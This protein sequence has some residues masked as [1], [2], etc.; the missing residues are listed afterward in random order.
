[1]KHKLLCIIVA[2]VTLMFFSK[3]NSGQAPDL[4]TAANFALFTSVGAVTNSGIPY[5]T[6]I[7]GNV[8]TNSDPT[9]TGFGNINGQ[10]H[11]VGD[12]GSTQCDADLLLASN[13]LAASIPDSTLGV[14]IGNGDTLPPGIYLMPG[15]ASLNLGLTLDAEGDPNA[16]FIFKTALAFSSGA[17]SKIYL[18]NGAQ[19]CNVFWKLDGAVTLGTGTTMR[20]TIISGGLISL[21][22]G[23]TLEGRALT[24]NGAILTDN[25]LVYTP[26]GCS[27]PAL[28]GPAAPSLVSMEC[29]TIF[30]SDGPVTNVGDTYVTGDVGT[31]NGL[32]TGY[33]PLFVTGMIHPIPDGATAAGA[34]DL[35]NAYAYLNALP[36]DIELLHPEM[37]GHNLVLTPHTYLMNG[38]VT[39]TDSLYLDAMGDADAIFII[40]T[41]GAFSTSTFSRVLLINGAIAKNI[42]WL[43][44]GAV[45]INDYSIFNGTIVCNNGAM[46]LNTGVIMNGR[47]LTTT[48]A[49]NTTAITAIMPPGCGVPPTNIITEPENIIVC[50]GDPA[51]FTVSVD[52]IGITYQWRIGTLNLTDGGNISGATTATLTIDP[53]TIADTSSF[54]NVVISG[55]PN[56]TSI[57]VSLMIDTG[58]VIITEPVNQTVCLGDSTGFTV[59]A[60]GSGLTYQWRNGTI[61]LIDGVNI[62]GA[63]SDTLVIN[64]V[65]LADTSSFYNVVITGAC[66]PSDTSINVSL[67]VDSVLAIITE[68]IDQ[69]VCDGNSVSFSVIASGTGLTYQWRNGNTDLI[70]GGNI[71]GANSATL[72]IDPA[73]IADTSSFYNVIISGSCGAN[74]TS[75][76]VSLGIDTSPEIIAEPI[77]QTACAGNSVSFS[78]IANGTGLTYQW[79]N[80]N[81]DLVNGG[82]IY[83]ANSATLIIDPANIADTSSFYNV[84]I[85]GSCGAN[86]TSMFV[87]LGIDTS[88]EIITEPAN[89]TACTGSSVSFSVVSTGLNFQWRNGVIDLVNGGNISGANS[90]T[91]II[92]PAN[93]ADTSSFYN[94]VVSGTCSTNDT[95]INVSLMLDEV[96]VIVT[97]P[98]NQTACAGNAVSFSVIATGTGLTYQ[99]RNGNTDLMNGGNISGANTATLIIDPANIAD[100]SSFYNVVVSGTCSP[101]VTSINVS[102]LLNSNL[103]I[104]SEP[105]SQF[106]C[107]GNLVN[108]SVI[109]SGTGLTYQWRNGNTDLIDGGNISGT[110]TSI[111]TINTATI[112]DTSSFYNVVV[113]GTCSTNDTSINVSLMLDEAPIIV[114]EPSNQTACA[115]NAVSFSVIATGAGLMYQW[116]NGNT[117]LINGGNISGAT[118]A[119]LTVNPAGISDV[120]TEYNVVVYG[121]CSSNDT[122]INVSFNLNSDPLIITEPT[123]QTVCEGSAVSFFVE[124]TGTGLTYQWR[125]GN[126]D[127][128]NGGTISG[129][130]SANLTINPSTAS[131]VATDY[132]VVITGTCVPYEY[133]NNVTL[134][135]NPIPVAIAT[136]NSPVCE[137]SSINLSAQA[138][139]N[140]TYL[141]TNA[142]GYSSTIQNSVILNSVF[143]DS[144]T[145]TLTVSANGCASVPSSLDVT[146]YKCLS[147]DFNIPE[148][149]S[150]N[151]DGINDVYVIRGIENYPGTSIIIF[152]RWG[153]KVFEASPYQNN[154]N[155]QSETG[156]KVGG[157]DLPIGSYFFLLDLNDDSKIIKGTIYLNR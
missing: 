150:P 30:S 69:I 16:V 142:N 128:L 56:D 36:H 50:E 11:Y 80:G 38:A 152:N 40:K 26:V 60:S 138:V 12:P 17:N 151:A 1:M 49:L 75:M 104:I 6:K 108:F 47:A 96:P 134:V 76:F 157:D 106:V 42:Y 18:I 115:G 146:V 103:L 95:S 148:G 122:S 111:L 132:N 64:P 35:L 117:D 2:V 127:L 24:T 86:D 71:S 53:A 137:G 92:D 85:S 102:L 15:A 155:G 136:S 141:W 153:N 25:V 133:S 22:S 140:G 88:P 139:E 126:T 67:M 116:R 58:V 98:S 78:I 99:W 110:A 37:F 20:G 82:N 83:G 149:F 14:V 121:T 31:N 107:A 7:T 79:R 41:Y 44:N 93:I 97:E 52:G 84:I 55:G 3:V 109:A 45:S 77:D 87:S 114:T 19:A 145:Y 70:N 94:V 4:G 130:N 129:A 154:W 34:T 105:S 113:S 74:D 73:N 46:D 23:D 81:T 144:G 66:A 120:G 27:S 51:V 147:L 48:G 5:L 100:T 131:D 118:S 39:F 125:R 135:V 124:A 123:N 112:A 156:L 8:G 29:F 101:S 61:D 91:L 9:I 89:Q 21:S 54:Y 13:F 90:T 10:M 33:N 28:T 63:T 72:I 32:T 59:S 65:S 119:T 43:V 57:F 68:P 143:A 62:F